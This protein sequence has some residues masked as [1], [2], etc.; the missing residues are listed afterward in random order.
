MSIETKSSAV[1]RELPLFGS[2][3]GI[4]LAD[5]IVEQKNTYTVAHC[6]ELDGAIDAERLRQS[7]RLGLAEADTVVAQYL[8]TPDGAAQ[9]LRQG[10]SAENL[11]LPEIHDLS[12]EADPES[13]ARLWMREDLSADLPADGERP[14]YLHRLFKLAG[15]A[16]ERW[17]WY[18]RYH[19]VCVDGYSFA[20]LTR[21]ISDLYQALGRGEA[22]SPSPFVSFADV[23]AE[24]DAYLASPRC[25]EDRAFWRDYAAALPSP[26]TLSARDALAG[27]GAANVDV[28]RRRFEIAG[29]TAAPQAMAAVFAYLARMGGKSR[30]AIGMPFMRR[31][32]SAALRA[33]GPVV[34]VLPVA[35]D[36]SDGDE[37]ATLAR[38]LADELKRV[39]RHER[40]DAEQIQRDSGMVGSRRALYGATLNLK[41]YDQSLRL[42]E[43]AGVT[44]P[45]AVGPIDDIE[46]GLWQQGEALVVELSANPARYDAAELEW[47]WNGMRGGCAAS[48]PPWPAARRWTK[49]PCTARRS[50]WRWTNG[51]KARASARRPACVPRWTCSCKAPRNMKTKPRWRAGANG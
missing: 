41:I 6:V 46:F 12:A 16:G 37:L 7:I 31:M 20:A 3:L 36:V 15:G 13:L 8:E 39:R 25:E 1:E 2:Q 32:G 33:V 23:A 44:L 35:L 40:Y 29:G 43:V 47:S 11:P 21:R 10:L 42:G 17:F 24:R 45:L 28:L 5:Q 22:P 26:S 14:L 50:E 48:S 30:V 38:R 34:N 19:H 4:W 49:R 51:R 9:L 27:E 18:Q